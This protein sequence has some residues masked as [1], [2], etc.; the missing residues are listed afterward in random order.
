MAQQ[1]PSMINNEDSLTN[2]AFNINTNVG[3]L[4]LYIGP[5]YAGK[6]SKLIEIYNN[7][8]NNDLNVIVLTHSSEI[9]YSIDQLSTHDK[10]KIACFKFD[11]INDFI[12]NKKSEIEISNIILID[13]AQFFEDLLEIKKLV[14][15]NDKDV[16]I[17]GLDGD[18]KRNKFGQIL[19]LIPY[20]DSI[21]KLKAKC[22]LCNTPA[23]F[24]SRII[25]SDQQI[26]IG[27]NESYQPLCRK[28][29]NTKHNA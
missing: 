20:C 29:Y 23:I 19:D 13:E 24:S 3:M 28:C 1:K 26:L 25:N 21:E 10:K 7:A 27:S 5:M 16:C 22:N 8:I 12:K 18:F 11:K 2:H 6:T 14:D 15:F 17:F 4:K 9:R